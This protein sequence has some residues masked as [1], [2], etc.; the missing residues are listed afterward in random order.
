MKT[1]NVSCWCASNQRPAYDSHYLHLSRRV[2]G[3][4][5]GLHRREGLVLVLGPGGGGGGGN[6]VLDQFCRLLSWFR[7]TLNNGCFSTARWC[8]RVNVGVCFHECIRVG[9]EKHGILFKSLQCW[10]SDAIGWL[11]HYGVNFTLGSACET[12]HTRLLACTHMCVVSSDQRVKLNEKVMGEG[13]A[14]VKQNLQ[15]C[16]LNEVRLTERDPSSRSS[17]PGVSHANV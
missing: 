1:I 4:Q 14:S 17:L 3:A 10:L 7:L 5:L 16:L 12:R 8:V 15:P 6:V 9:A 11:F 13:R 2:S